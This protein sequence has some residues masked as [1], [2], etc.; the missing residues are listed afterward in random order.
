[1]NMHEPAPLANRPHSDDQRSAEAI[2]VLIRMDTMLSRL[3]ERCL[4]GTFSS[5]FDLCLFCGAAV[6]FLA[7]LQSELERN[8][9]VLL[10]CYLSS[11]KGLPT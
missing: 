1:M 10:Q 3:L 5:K 11:S 8:L 4:E 6:G 9:H 7:Q 2:R